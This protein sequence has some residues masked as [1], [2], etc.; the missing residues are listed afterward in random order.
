M[1]SIQAG[2]QPGA[3]CSRDQKQQFRFVCAEIYQD[4]QSMYKD[5]QSMYEDVPRETN[6]ILRYIEIYPV[7]DCYT[8]LYR[9]IPILVCTELYRV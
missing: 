4:E 1:H 7:T 9:V 5:E 3:G 8:E 6:V 2:G